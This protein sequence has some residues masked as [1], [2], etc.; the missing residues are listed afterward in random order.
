MQLTYKGSFDAVEIVGHVDVVHQGE[1]FDVDPFLARSLLE[2]TDN[3]DP[4]DDEAAEVLAALVAEAL[5]GEDDP[6]PDVSSPVALDDLTIAQ[7]RD[8]AAKLTP[9]IDLTGLT[10]KAE[11]VA[12][13]A[14]HDSNN[15]TGA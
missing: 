2:Q 14:G 4:A 7:L 1:T 15:E 3:Y 10:L 11:L 12:A 8:Y 13:I 5:A 9:P 6:L